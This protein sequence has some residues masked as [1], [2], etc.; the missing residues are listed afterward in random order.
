MNDGLEEEDFDN[1]INQEISDLGYINGDND[2]FIEDPEIG[3]WD[4]SK[5]E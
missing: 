2:S 3:G 5:I 1:M 4:Q